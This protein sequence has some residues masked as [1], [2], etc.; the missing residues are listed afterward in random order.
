ML[1]IRV[2]PAAGEPTIGNVLAKRVRGEV[3]RE[4]LE[5]DADPAGP[6]DVA[7]AVSH[8]WPVRLDPPGRSH[9]AWTLRIRL[10]D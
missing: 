4:L 6:D 1:T 8:R 2:L 7:D 3:A 10:S 9:R 5:S